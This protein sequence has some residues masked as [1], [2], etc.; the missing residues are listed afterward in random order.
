ML[1]ADVEAANIGLMLV[2]DDLMA[3]LLSLCDRDAARAS[4]FLARDVAMVMVGGE[5][6][7]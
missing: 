2:V 4:I 3:G 6:R 1:L 5:M 7:V